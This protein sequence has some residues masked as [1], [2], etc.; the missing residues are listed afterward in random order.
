MNTKP[1]I[2][3]THTFHSRR[4]VCEVFGKKI[5][6]RISID[7]QTS[8]QVLLDEEGKQ[9]RKFRVDNLLFNVVFHGHFSVAF[10]EQRR[11]Q[12]TTLHHRPDF[13]MWM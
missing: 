10:L 5:E 8:F 13:A 6:K 2:S 3:F 7:G 12:Q 9:N 1:V 11:F 4:L